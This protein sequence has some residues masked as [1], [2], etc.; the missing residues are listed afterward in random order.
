[1]DGPGFARARQASHHRHQPTRLLGKLGAQE[2][3]P[4]RLRI[5]IGLVP[6]NARRHHKDVTD[7]H[8]FVGA[9]LERLDIAR[10]V[11]VQALDMA[12]DDRSS[13]QRR[14]DGFHHRHRH[15]AG[16]GTVAALVGLVDHRAVL[17]HEEAG[18]AVESKSIVEVVGPLADRNQ[19]VLEADLRL[20]QIARLPGC[21][22]RAGRE[23][24]VDVAEGA[25]REIRLEMAVIDLLDRSDP[26][27]GMAVA[28]LACFDA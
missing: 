5:G 12:V 21:L 18:D 1:M 20:R 15:P 11:V 16:V 17:E 3:T 6:G 9:A 2:I 14:G 8:P 13:D 4:V 19:D 10:D 22:D 23:Q 26:L 25:D 24:A 28:A 27:C 7:T